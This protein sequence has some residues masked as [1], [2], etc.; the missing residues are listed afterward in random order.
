M[1]LGLGLGWVQG[2]GWGWGEGEGW[3]ESE[4]WGAGEGQDPPA[5]SLSLLYL[6]YISPISR[7]YL[8]LRD[9]GRCELRSADEVARSVDARRGRHQV[10]T[11]LD[12]AIARGLDPDRLEAQTLGDRA[13]ARRSQ[14]EVGLRREG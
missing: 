11:H 5:R 6:A 3:G 13:P 2:E 10:R 1:G 8:R 4:G 12:V 14:H 9:P 7:L